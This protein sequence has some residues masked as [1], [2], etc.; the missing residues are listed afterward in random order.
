MNTTQ[1]IGRITKDPEV[2]KTPQD[3]SVVTFTLAVNRKFSK[4]DEADFIRVTAWE[5]S[6][7][8]I[9]QYVLK[10]DRLAIVGRIQTGSHQDKDGKTVYTTEVV[11]HDV[12]TLETKKDR[13]VSQGATYQNK[14]QRDAQVNQEFGGPT[15]DITSDDLPF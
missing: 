5:Q 6:A 15:L 10:G 13:E 9:G 8:F 12:T 3:K 7:D 14:P 1:L 4:S 2:R 11:T